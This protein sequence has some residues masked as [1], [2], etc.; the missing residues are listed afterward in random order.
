MMPIESG[1]IPSDLSLK[2]ISRSRGRPIPSSP[3]RCSNSILL[4]HSE[5]Y[6]LLVGT[7]LGCYC[8]IVAREK[9]PEP[10]RYGVFGSLRDAMIAGKLQVKVGFLA[11]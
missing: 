3:E 9:S 11:K 4:G 1:P 2:T 10:D 7:T 6:K 5:Q 8:W